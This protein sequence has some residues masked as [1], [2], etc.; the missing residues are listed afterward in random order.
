MNIMWSVILFLV[1]LTT[2]VYGSCFF[3]Q[4]SVDQ[5][6]TGRFRYICE[7]SL[8]HGGLS[9][10]AEFHSLLKVFPGSQFTTTD[11]LKCDCTMEGLQCCGIGRMGGVSVAPEGCVFLT[12]GCKQ[13]IVRRNDS[14]LD[15]FSGEPIPPSAADLAMTGR[16]HMT[17]NTILKMSG[18]MSTSTS[19]KCRNST[20]WSNNVSRVDCLAL[21][22]S[23]QK[24]GVLRTA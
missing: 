19:R 14:S 2:Y 6:E 18:P 5:T 3:K 8:S 15:C 10:G 12:D 7:Y 24:R 17:G 23:P 4:I 11:C 13:L 20:A 9:K 1:G 16:G 21:E 22:A